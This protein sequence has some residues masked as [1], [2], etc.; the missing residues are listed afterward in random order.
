MRR[1]IMLFAVGLAAAT[2]LTVEAAQDT[3]TTAQPSRLD[4][5]AI[6]AELR[7]IIA[8]RYV[9][10][11]RRPALDAVLAQGLAS[12]RYDVA[13]PAALA[14][15]INED[16]ERV[17][18]DRHLGFVFDPRQ[19]AML[20]MREDSERPDPSAF[21]RQM[22]SINHGVTELRVLPGNVRYME[23]TGFAWIGPESA[24]A[25][26]NAVRFLAGGDAIVIDI[27]RN[28]GG[29]SDASQYLLSHFLPANHPLFTYYREGGRVSR[30][31]TLPQV[32]AGRITGKPLYLLTS[33]STASAA[34]E[35]TGN[36]AGYR[37]GEVIGETTA[38]AGFA[39]DLVPIR[40]DFV[41]S[42]SIG[43]VVLASTGRDWEAT[44]IS[45][46]IRTPAPQALDTA[47]AHAL[48]RLAA[49]A[50][51]EARVE[52]EALAEG[53]AARVEPRS[54]ALTLAAYAGGFGERRV[55]AEEGRLYYQLADRPRRVLVPL[56]G[57]VFAFEDDPGMR[58]EFAQSGSRVTALEIG[59]P[60]SPPQGRYA[61]TE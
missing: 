26:E 5:H 53:I 7:R 33:N 48:R 40:G 25:L 27:R 4:P 11:E 1:L 3:Q 35:F 45:P 58:L 28:G 54:P 16:L 52:L 9:V 32:A 10:S 21:E 42:I 13:D 29:D 12:G 22:R 6:V 30:V 46:T 8:Q 59:R 37:L 15:R 24:A 17:G 2:P 47:H 14:E 19:A 43:R 39:A 60:G 18:R 36:F 49:T 51:P 20:A 57:N 38:G 56:G 41:L 34:E 50:P 44:G 31:S 61:R 23:Y 55:R